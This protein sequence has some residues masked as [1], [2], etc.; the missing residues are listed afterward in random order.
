MR[1]P[2]E[3]RG[4]W[5]APPKTPIPTII[6]VYYIA[7]A[8]AAAAIL[9]TPSS[10]FY[11]KT[12]DL[13]EEQLIEHFENVAKLCVARNSEGVCVAGNFAKK[14]DQKRVRIFVEAKPL[15]NP[16]RGGTPPA[17]F[18]RI[19]DAARNLEGNLPFTF[20]FGLKAS[21]ITIHYGTRKDLISLLNK[22]MRNRNHSQ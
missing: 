13:K 15:Y 18:T 6:W 2:V 1:P 9:L 12:N 21:D 8:L 10:L 11:E 5:E 3:T 4:R 17:Y 19:V 22:L 7:S 14:W 20:K 16:D